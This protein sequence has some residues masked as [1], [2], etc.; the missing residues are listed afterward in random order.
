MATPITVGC[1]L[2]IAA[3]KNAGW[4]GPVLASLII[5]WHISTQHTQGPRDLVAVLVMV[6]GMLVTSLCRYKRLCV[7]EVQSA[8]PQTVDRTERVQI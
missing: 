2:C 4:A 8:T 5:C 3:L 1:C 6:E 7:A